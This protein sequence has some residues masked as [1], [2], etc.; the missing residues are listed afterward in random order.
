MALLAHIEATTLLNK[1][2]GG[3]RYKSEA[4]KERGPEAGMKREVNFSNNRL[5]YENHYVYPV[6]HGTPGGNI[7]HP[8]GPP[9]AS[10]GVNLGAAPMPRWSFERCPSLLPPVLQRD[11]GRIGRSVA[12]LPPSS[13]N[14]PPASTTR[15]DDETARS[16]ARSTAR[17][18]TTSQVTA[19][20]SAPTLS[21]VQSDPGFGRSG[22]V[23]KFSGLQ[24][25]IGMQWDNAATAAGGA[26]RGGD[27]R[28]LGF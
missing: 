11:R 13:L 4:R 24:G 25:V 23:P 28:Y 9:G 20:A 18:P 26:Y 5:P 21:R 15:T 16:T 10:R 2:R 14:D 6:L 27:G 19:P 12:G 7:A 1:P 8:R 17:M 3:N 22:H